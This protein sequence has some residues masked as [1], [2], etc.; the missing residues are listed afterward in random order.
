MPTPSFF[1]Y[2]SQLSK[3]L[4]KNARTDYQWECKLIAEQF[5]TM[6]QSIIFPSILKVYI[7]VCPQI[8]CMGI[9][10]KEMTKNL[11]K[12]AHIS[13]VCSEKLVKMLKGWK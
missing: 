3:F 4:R 13:R 8:P 11:H 5:D 10:P 9:F 6:S 1:V 2:G 7:P 12:N